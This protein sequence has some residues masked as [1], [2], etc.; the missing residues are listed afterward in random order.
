MFHSTWGF[1]FFS[2]EL[3]KGSNVVKQIM[4]L[5]TQQACWPWTPP[6]PIKWS[7][8]TEWKLLAQWT[9]LRSDL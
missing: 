1:F 4:L 6:G 8:G 2:L 5:Y 7:A 3:L 9:S